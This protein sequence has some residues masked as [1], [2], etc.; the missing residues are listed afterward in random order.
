MCLYVSLVPVAEFGNGRAECFSINY[1]D[2]L[3]AGWLLAASIVGWSKAGRLARCCSKDAIQS[4]LLWYSLTISYAVSLNSS[5]KFVLE[6]H[7][8]LISLGDRPAD[9]S[10]KCHR[11]Q[12]AYLFFAALDVGILHAMHARYCQ[13]HV[14][15]V[16]LVS[17]AKKASNTKIVWRVEKG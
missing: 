12:E 5:S 1:R 9:S 7:I 8:C 6:N 4:L 17:K 16:S 2:S 3:G 14:N 13:T 10:N 11:M 15:R